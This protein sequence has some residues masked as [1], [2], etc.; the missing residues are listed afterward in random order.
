MKTAMIVALAVLAVLAFA[1]GTA[2]ACTCGFLDPT[3]GSLWTDSIITYFN[4]TDAAQSIV[5][6]PQQSADRYG[7]D[8]AG[9]SGDGQQPWVASQRVNVW[10]DDFGST[11]RSAVSFNNSYFS[12]RSS[13]NGLSMQVS[14]ADTVNRISYGSQLVSRRRDIL[15]GSFRAFV[16]PSTPASAGTTFDMEVAYNE[17]ELMRSAIFSS[18]AYGNGTLQYSFSARGVDAKPMIYNFSTLDANISTRTYDFRQY[19]MDWLPRSL[20]FAN[21]G[22]NGT[23]NDTT[24]E[25]N[26]K[27]NLP[28]VGAPWS[29]KHW[30]NGSPTE[31]C[32][33][34]IRRAAVAN[35]LWAR[36]FF[37]SSL[38][39]RTTDFEAQCASSEDQQVCSTE[40]FTL[41][42]VTP[43][44]LLATQ[45]FR[46][47]KW[48]RTF[49]LYSAIVTAAAGGIFLMLLIHALCK[50]YL[51]AQR[52]KREFYAKNAA[53]EM[54][55]MKQGDDA[56]QLTMPSVDSFELSREL[57]FLDAAAEVWDNPALIL[58]DAF[59]DSDDDT[60]YSKYDF[61][62]PLRQSSLDKGHKQPGLNDEPIDY[63]PPVLKMSL[64]PARGSATTVVFGRSSRDGSLAPELR[65]DL[66]APPPFRRLSRPDPFPIQAVSQ[67]CY[68][69]LL[70]RL[71]TV[72]PRADSHMTQ[73]SEVGGPGDGFGQP[74]SFPYLRPQM[75]SEDGT[76]APFIWATRIAEW[77]PAQ[78]GDH[79]EEVGR[80]AKSPT[81]VPQ[82]TVN[83]AA[84]AAAAAQ[85]PTGGLFSRLLLRIR[86]KF[87]VGAGDAKATA[88]GAARIDYLDGLRGF[89]CLLVALHHWL[90]INYYSITTPSA[91]A[92]YQWEDTITRV[93]GAVIANGGLNVGIFFTVSEYHR[94]EGAK[95][96]LIFH[97]LTSS[98][99]GSSLI[100]TSSGETCKISLNRSRPACR[101]SA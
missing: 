32:G 76:T 100:A 66:L 61:D 55:D 3:T 21:D 98:Q 85:P 50:R 96:S 58:D 28:S 16:K 83:S 45:H 97:S 89:A 46:P 17:S 33:P 25:K 34:P 95:A 52:E 60:V 101:V 11:W 42:E 31:S 35:I 30:S 5:S 69:S 13:V 62:D 74:P 38:P 44:N 6:N 10:E 86:E 63:V 19:R 29:F 37:N 36:L 57:N 24:V 1:R 49:P 67:D 92:H 78:N 47:P 82:Q 41:R 73:V 8:D 20:V 39:S 18:D 40:D 27:T 15:F 2:A 71:H 77:Q 88:S 14:P 53:L 9:I 48:S 70:P 12:N 59:S 99:Q 79:A 51:K 81:V 65:H 43:F 22:T 84:T 64:R 87:F 54:S 7:Q 4:E 94:N 80:L 26:D 75:R 23:S 93:L 72:R 91:P 90:L 56:P 68:T